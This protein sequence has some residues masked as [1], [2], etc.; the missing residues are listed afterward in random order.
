[1][2]LSEGKDFSKV[3]MSES[4]DTTSKKDLFSNKGTITLGNEA[5]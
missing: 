3:L 5:K 2:E 4:P 1:V